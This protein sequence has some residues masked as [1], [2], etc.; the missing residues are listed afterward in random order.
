MVS[1]TPSFSVLYENSILKICISKDV[2]ID[3]QIAKEIISQCTQI[4]NNEIHANLVDL[5]EMNFVY[6][7]AR[8]FFASQ[9]QSTVVAIAILIGSQIQA[10]FANLYFKFNRPKL[11]TKLFA[12]ELEAVEWLQQEINKRKK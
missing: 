5:R 9:D 3:L 1:A 2:I 7:D 4:S 11:R 12:D 10:S 6:N 8:Q